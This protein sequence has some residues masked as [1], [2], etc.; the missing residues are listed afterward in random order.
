MKPASEWATD[1]L[2]PVDATLEEGYMAREAWTR[3]IR[4]V[5]VDAL[6]WALTKYSY[7]VCAV[8]KKLEGEKA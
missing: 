4:A 8:I 1:W 3:R 2:G 5:Q 6:K 7:D